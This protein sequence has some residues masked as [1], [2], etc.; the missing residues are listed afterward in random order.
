MAEVIRKSTNKFTKGIVMDFSPENTKNDTLTY[1]LNATLLTFNGN[2]LSLQ[3]DVGNARVE[4]AYLPEGYIPVGTCEYGGIIY[5]VS[6]NPLE[7]KSQIGCFPSPE[8]N[9][10]SDELGNLVETIHAS[11]F[12]KDGTIN[13][14]S[15]CV[16]LKHDSLNPGD[17]FIISANESI[18]QERLADLQTSTENSEYKPVS[19]PVLALNVVSIEDSGKIV[20]LN[21]SLRTYEFNSGQ[22]D[23]IKYNYHILGS[24]ET[25]AENLNNVDIDSYRNVLSSGYNVF[26]S[27]TSGKL[28]ILAEL[29]AIDSYSVTHSVVPRTELQNGKLTHNAGTFDVIIHT[30]V[31]PNLTPENYDVNPK[32]K[33]YYLKDSQGYLQGK[34]GLIPLFDSDNKTNT[35]LNTTLDSVYQPTD[36][37]D[38][39]NYSMKSGNFDFPKAKTYHSSMQEYTGDIENLQENKVYTKFSEK[40][41]HRVKVKQI[42]E[43]LN[44]TYYQLEYFYR[45]LNAYLYKYNSNSTD[46]I[47][48]ENGESVKREYQYY[49]KTTIIDYVDVE[50]NVDYQSSILYKAEKTPQLASS[51]IIKDASIEKYEEIQTNSYIEASDS[52]VGPFYIRQETAS[53]YD[54]IKVENRPE[55]GVYYILK[56]ITSLNYVGTVI[57]DIT[58]YNTLYYY[59]DTA[60]FKLATSE[61]IDKYWSNS[62]PDLALYVKTE[63]DRFEKISEVD[64]IKYVENGIDVYYKNEYT[65]VYVGD[66]IE[67][68]SALNDDSDLFISVPSDA[69]VSYEMFKPDVTI[70]YIEGNDKPKPLNYPKD[71]ALVLYTIGDFLPINNEYTDVRLATLQLPPIITAK[72][73]PDLP[74]KYDYT[75]VPC[76]NYGRLDKLA[77]SNTV[78]FSK[79]RDFDKSDFSVW[80]YHIDGNQLSLTFGA[81]VYDTFETNKVDGLVLEFYDLR[82]FAGSL[83]I[84][85]KKAYSGTFTYI[86]NLNTLGSIGKTKY[87]NGNLSTSYKHNI[88]IQ[89]LENEYRYKNTVLNFDEDRGWLGLEDSDNDCGT[90]YSNML[91]GVKTYLRVTTNEEITYIPKRD[92]FLY[93]LPIY[94]DYYYNIEDFSTLHN[95]TLDMILTYKLEDHGSNQA[96]QDDKI[97]NGY[98]NSDE[99][100]KYLN[101]NFDKQTL[102]TIKYYQYSGISKVYLE[103]GLKKDYEEFGLSY[104]PQI[105]NYFKCT[106]ALKGD[107]N[108]SFKIQTKDNVGS[109]YQKLNYENNFTTTPTNFVQ[110]DNDDSIEY[111]ISCPNFAEFNFIN[112]TYQIPSYVAIAYN[113][114]V[115][116]KINIQNIATVDVPATT[117]CALCHKINSVDYNYNDFNIRVVT[118]KDVD[119]FYSDVMFYNTGDENAYIFGVCRQMSESSTENLTTVCSAYDTI[120]DVPTPIVTKGKFNAGEPLKQMSSYIGKLSIGQPHV[121]GLSDEYR[122]NIASN[123]DVVFP[124]NVED[125]YVLKEKEW[126]YLNWKDVV[127]DMSPSIFNFIANTKDSIK[128]SSEFISVIPYAYMVYN[129]DKKARRSYIGLSPSRLERYNAGLI[130]SMKS[131]YAY[132]PDYSTVS[133]K[134]GD[135]VVENKEVQIISNLISKDAGFN[136]ESVDT[137]N[138]FILLSGIPISTYLKDLSTYSDIITHIDNEPIPQLNFVPG[139]KYCGTKDD[140]YLI[141]SITYNIPEPTDLEEELQFQNKDLIIVKKEDGSTSIL[142]GDI[143]KKRLYGF[144]EN[145]LIQLDVSNYT[146]DSSDGTLQIDTDTITKVENQEFKI[147]FTPVVS[148]SPLVSMY[149]LN[150]SGAFK[151][152]NKTHQFIGDRTGNSNIPIKSEFFFRNNESNSGK[153]LYTENNTFVIKE[154]LKEGDNSIS[155]YMQNT[156]GEKL[157]LIHPVNPVTNGNLISKDSYKY[158][159]V[160]VVICSY[161][162]IL[163]SSDFA[164]GGKYELETLPID[165]LNAMLDGT[166]NV[167]PDGN[168]YVLYHTSDVVSSQATENSDVDISIGNVSK[169]NDFYTMVLYKITLETVFYIVERHS[170]IHHMLDHVINVPITPTNTYSNWNANVYT[171]NDKYLNRCLVN[172]SITLNDLEYDPSLDGHRL[173]VNSARYKYCDDPKNR[174]YYRKDND[175]DTKSNVNC[176]YVYTGPCFMPYNYNHYKFVEIV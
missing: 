38:F 163:L 131:I 15:K 54:F 7:D 56:I 165:L 152:I 173:Y 17:K 123:A 158:S 40:C 67:V 128:Y 156:F 160:P 97:K 104:L 60:D 72:S 167:M 8:R 168:R 154:I 33:Y 91:Y 16:L 58:D 151:V 116:H 9:I 81:N 85:N 4:T 82:G 126:P 32:L 105:N 175:G 19:N 164:E 148:S 22:D 55:E 53:G 114:V 172:T 39:K 118:D 155:I 86:I 89:K 28:A 63:V 13:N 24:S 140:P 34:D 174:I 133:I 137:F 117:V 94:N 65:P 47:K 90:L 87:V 84:L 107:S 46:Y 83:E 64:L 12:I 162:R 96:Y 35:F 134:R 125:V 30:E 166:T 14:T 44:D 112:P 171:V 110:F 61:E 1:A 113:F 130:K 11:D 37:L 111:N 161:Q 80:K 120:T 51:E 78:D 25:S 26:R 153:V 147:D 18:Y 124:E 146:I 109:D 170:Y 48:L 70:N 6:Y 138:D 77:V 100:H 79:L 66:I 142:K 132:N 136:F 99:I 68:G 169:T 93:T 129:N 135:I 41:Y 139:C 88:G 21:S 27:K 2:E 3:N 145:H 45:D 75:L 73:L 59:P 57:K 115:G 31:G 141:S 98:V 42:K 23:S 176:L 20:Y 127:K 101:G 52:D 62:D 29:I 10:S 50:H 150:T 108:K 119:K 36:A 76:M 74:F 122:T 49:I 144:C 102:E 157:N 159:I 103:V 106:L 92:F 71:D 95:P 143:D 69:Y 43:R 5:I 121:H 149:M